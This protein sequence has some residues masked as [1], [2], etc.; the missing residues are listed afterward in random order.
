M[1]QNRK[2]FLT[3]ILAAAASGCTTLGRESGDV[4]S[5]VSGTVVSQSGSR[6]PVIA[7]KDRG[8]WLEMRQKKDLRARTI[9]SMATGEA[10]AAVGLAKAQLAKNPGNPDALNQLAAAL[11]LTKNY[12][13]ASYYASLADKVRPGNAETLNIRGLA[14]MLTP[15]ARMHDF[16]NAAVFFQQAMDADQKQIAA[17]LNL[18]NLY[19]ELGNSASAE[20]VFAQVATRCGN[21]NA[22]LLGL[23]VAQRRVGK[24]EAALA[25]FQTVLKKQPSNSAALFNIALVYNN[26]L[27][28][29]KE[30]E[31]ALNKLLASKSVTDFAVRKKAHIVLRRIKGDADVSERM[32]DAPAAD[33][34]SDAELLMSS[35]EF[36]E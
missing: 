4:N 3:V 28:N 23:G 7:G 18:G 19:L 30:A 25:S 26:G 12:D 24:Y 8:Y 9:G 35:S 15:S 21:C 11:A 13:L 29:R 1:F 6:N 36:E 16:R 22:G 34:G 10:Q 20:S 14:A 32:A 17:G 31:A 27:N 5:A 33:D 2:I